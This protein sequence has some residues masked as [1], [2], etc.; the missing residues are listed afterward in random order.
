MV[1]QGSLV[2][3]DQWIYSV[4][5]S[6]LLKFNSSFSGF[7]FN[8]S[9]D[10]CTQALIILHP[11]ETASTVPQSKG[12]SLLLPW[13][14]RWEAWNEVLVL[15]PYWYH[16]LK[17]FSLEKTKQ[18]WYSELYFWEANEH[19]DPQSYENLDRLLEEHWRTMDFCLRRAFW[20]TLFHSSL[21][22]GQLCLAWRQ[23]NLI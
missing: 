11:Y 2:Y 5:N 10:V 17:R 16:L 7:R 6:S 1:L 14:V 9:T 4:G 22:I 12:E 19:K 13:C 18:L 23:L 15:S 21:E 8:T 20:M 3:K